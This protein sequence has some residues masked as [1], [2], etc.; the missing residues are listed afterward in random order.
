MTDD[1]AFE[2]DLRAML[3]ARDPGPPSPDLIGAVRRR[4]AADQGLWRLVKI[5]HT[6][7]SIAIVATIAAI[8]VLAVVVARPSSVSPGSTPLPTPTIPYSIRA[9]DG[10]VRGESYPVVQIALALILAGFLV[11][12]YARATVRRNRITSALGIA[13]L[14]LVALRIGTP[15]AVAFGAIGEEALDPGGH[16]PSGGNRFFVDVVGDSPFTLI[17]TVSNASRL[18][19]EIEGISEP[20]VLLPGMIPQVRFVGVGLIADPSLDLTAQ[21]RFAFAPLT[22]WPGAR[23]DLALLGMAGHCAISPSTAA[24]GF[25]SIEEVEI[26]YEQLTLRHTAT[27]VLPEPVN[28]SEPD[29]CP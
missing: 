20:P 11:R 3:D 4:L 28:V 29:H 12:A 25:T 14:A 21:P 19:L 10:V 17:L 22:L 6:A 26:V 7:G 27:V 5:G 8:V 18:P 13:I 23:V 24:G 16:D 2:R 15:D 9:G 1:G